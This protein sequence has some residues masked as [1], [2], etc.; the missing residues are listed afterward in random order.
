MLKDLK[1]IL[2]GKKECER[3]GGKEGVRRVAVS[4][5]AGMIASLALLLAV[6]SIQSTC[7]FMAYQ[8]DVPNELWDRIS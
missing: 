7:L 4:S 8:P 6:S 1:S 5:F 3:C 2:V